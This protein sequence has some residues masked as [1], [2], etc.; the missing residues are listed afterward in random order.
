MYNLFIARTPMQILNAFEATHHFKTQRNILVIIHNRLN[1]NEEQIKKIIDIFNL[2][3]IFTEII[4]IENRGKS[5]FKQAKELIK[6]LQNLSYDYVFL[7]SYG[8]VG[9]LLLANIKYQKSYLIDDGTATI[10]AHKAIMKKRGKTPLGFK[11]LRALFFGLKIKLSKPISF[12]TIFHLEAI[13]DEIIVKHTFE[14]VKKQFSQEAARSEA[15]YLLGQSI[16]QYDMISEAKYIDYIKQ[17]VEYYPDEKIIYVPHRAEV[18]NKE[19]NLLVNKNFSI[20]P[21]TMPIELYF[22]INKINPKHV[23]SF[24]T[25]ALYTL[26]VLFSQSKVESFSI[27]PQDIESR[28]EIVRLCHALFH[29]TSIVQTPLQKYSERTT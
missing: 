10:V 24:F 2:N 21:S 25:S 13:D 26:N 4:E 17:I 9:R 14:H 16:T 18:H 23:I 6:T 22:L 12:F 15:I 20:L 28:A 27:D 7:G 5:K 3:H 29:T 19:L 11:E 8:S 1:N